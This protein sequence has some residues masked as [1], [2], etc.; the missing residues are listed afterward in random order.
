MIA[1]GSA[2]MKFVRNLSRM[3][4][5]CVLVATIVVSLINDR[6]SPKKAPP[7]VA[8]VS[9]A[10]S[11]PAVFDI[12]AAIGIKAAIVPTEVPIEREMMHAA[13]NIPGSSMLAGSI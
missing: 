7:T 9:M 11:M 1:A 2:I 3:A 6:L 5:P 13:K 12:S 8:A 4:H 10:I